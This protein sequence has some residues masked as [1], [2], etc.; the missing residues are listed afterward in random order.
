[1]PQPSVASTAV[2]EPAVIEVVKARSVQT[3]FQPVVS[4]AAK[5]IVGF[6]AFSKGGTGKDGTSLI[7]PAVL[8]HDELSPETKISV[9]RLCRETALSQ[10]KPIHAGHKGLL[11]FLNLNAA[12]LAHVE[13]KT[14]VLK[15]QVASMDISMDN[16]VVEFPVS[17]AARPEVVS[18]VNCY[19][20]MGFKFSLDNC[21][22]DDGI[23]RALSSV[24]PSFIKIRP[25]LYAEG[26]NGA[27]TLAALKRLVETAER[28]GAMVV[29]QGVENEAD[30]IRLLA[31]GVHLQQ[32]Y[33]YSKDEGGPAGQAE[34]FSRKIQNT[35]EKYKRVGRELVRQKK[36]RF[37]TMFRSVGAVCTR[38]A[39]MSESRF[40]EVCRAMVKNTEGVVSVFVLDESGTQITSRPHVESASP[41]VSATVIGSAKGVDHSVQDYFL[42]LDMGYEKFVTPPFVS[43]F[44]GQNVCLVSRPIYNSENTRYVVCVETNH[45]G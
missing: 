14:K 17:V 21:G 7:E 11:L 34:S 24:R 15:H 29:A 27:D 9:D 30:S 12:I 44:T 5:S 39:G 38:L 23:G 20:E 6:E 43:P 13:T 36:E 45:P 19:R 40:E 31:A 32:G 1:M 35:H 10:F 8:F 3:Y 26:D 25:E 18:F 42:Y 37:Q 22:G 4:L 16:V 28:A 41:K 33:Y 2:N